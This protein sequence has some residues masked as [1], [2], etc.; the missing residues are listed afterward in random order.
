MRTL[1]RL[2]RSPRRVLAALTVL[3]AVAVPA[4]ASAATLNPVGTLVQLPGTAGCITGSS[5]PRAGCA[6]ARALKGPAPFLGSQALALSPDGKNVYVASSSSNAIAVFTRDATTGKLAQ[7]P[8]TAGCVA[9]RAAEGCG[10][11]NGLEGPNSV[12][13]SP[14]GTS[15]YATAFTSGAVSSY[16]RDPATGA[17]TQTGCVAEAGLVPGCGTARGI[18]G[19]DVVTVSPDGRNVYVGAFTGSAVAVLTRDA[20]TGTLTQPAGAAGCVGGTSSD[21][22][23]PGVTMGSIE[24]LAISGDGANVYAAAATGN[25]VDAFSRDSTT[26]ALTQTDCLVNTATTGC[27]TATRVAGANTV[28]VGASDTDVYVTSL[29]S[30]TLTSFTRGEESS[31]TQQSGTSA[32]AIFVLAVGCSLGHALSAPEGVAVSPDGASVYAAAFTS[33]AIATFDRSSTG[34]LM[35]KP[36]KAG[37]ISV[38]TTPNCAPGRALRGVS[39][40]AVSGDGKFVYAASFASSSVTVFARA[41]KTSAKKK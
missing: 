39:S 4:G 33:G 9:A 25:A 40:L 17:L 31:L 30:N 41:T 29:I 22:C 21:G 12:A 36:R 23:A 16:S 10:A 11:A 14:D 2:P 35:Q 13:V 7:A 37:C 34:T 38:R 6:P 20:A 19:P 32:C 26:G 8:G 15:V 3:G 28:A 18:R 27:T 24:G 1:T 5:V